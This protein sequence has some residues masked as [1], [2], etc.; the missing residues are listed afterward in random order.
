LSALQDNKL[1]ILIIEDD[2]VDRKLLE[3]FLM[4]SSL[5]ASK[6]ASAGL[7]TEALD[8]V[9]SE[10][11][12]IVLSDL[13]L[14]DSTGTTAIDQLH[15]VAPLVPV[16]VMSGQDDEAVAV[17]A[18]QQG[19]QDYLIKGQVDSQILVRAIRY[20]VERKKAE[21]KLQEAEQNY[22]TIFDN[23]AVAI[24]MVNEAGQLISWNQF[25]ANLL[26]MTE[27]D[28]Y[29]RPIE[30][31]YPKEEWV[32]I[33]DQNI[34][35]K[36][37]QHHLETRMIKKTG[38]I[39]DVDISLTVLKDHA[40]SV[41]GSIG[42]IRDITER[43]EAEGQLERSYALLNA[44]L[45][46]TADGLLAVDNEG[47]LASHNEKFSDMWGLSK[48]SLTEMS[49]HDVVAAMGE[50]LIEGDAFLAELENAIKVDDTGMLE[51]NGVLNF[52]DGR[53]IEYYSKPQ[54][55]SKHVTARVFSFRDVTERKRVHE[56]LE[57][58]QKN[59][60]AIFDAAPI[61]MLLVDSDLKVRRANDAVRA[62]VHRE[63]A[64]II[65]YHP[66]HALGCVNSCESPQN[67]MKRCGDSKACL[68][69]PLFDT[70]S[71][72]LNHGQAIH[73]VEI[74]PHLR[75]DGKELHP[76]L[77]ISTESVTIDG[78]R[79][80]VVAA[81]DITERVRAERELRETMEIK[82]QFISTVSHELR[83]PLASMK[84]SVLI[85]LDGV[86]GPINQDQTH[87][88]DVARRNIDRLWR[89]INDVLDF[90]KLG[91]GRMTFQMN[92]GDLIRTVEEAYSTMVQM[93]N[94]G[95]VNLALDI[96][97]DTPLAVYDSD[98]M[99]QVLT[100]LMSNAIKFTPENGHV[101]VGAQCVG[102]EFV[103]TIKDTGL[104]IP[105]EDLSKVFERFYRVNR[106]GKE[107]TGTGLGLAIVRRIIDA[108]CG[109]IDVQSTVGEGTTFVIY[110]PV[111]TQ[112]G[113]CVLGDIEDRTVESTIL[114]G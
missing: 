7:L 53:I 58:K 44:T 72:S 26:E 73:G 23:S 105:K 5:S 70:I 69:C 63:Y 81:N 57:R 74:N 85:V 103:L 28:L 86:A 50:Q 46:S 34:R 80:S 66:G 98:R 106:P 77:S 3:R 104:G 1:N 90:Q 8:M 41:T 61:G 71:K 27:E 62:M 88:L 15:R 78:E 87:F 47:H 19:A 67:K 54:A 51:K 92:E 30:A 111:T 56:I 22:R 36:G 40:G 31:F 79:F 11:F 112:K 95:H 82:S 68:N 12:D 13:G 89:L 18:V 21:R 64:D 65:G 94:K 59:L 114:A 2:V 14:P 33:C 97:R 52:K 25:T 108:H 113:T 110:L 101:S 20:A 55:V 84:E 32:K 38:G 48:I 35:L 107:I 99:I 16:I 91:A 24:M 49:Y 93:A 45:E 9:Q 37:M 39:I 75:I 102:Q 76:W 6:V 83:T 96:Q 10:D 60:E 4:R 17:Q 109:R 42:V 100:N 43:K 29:L